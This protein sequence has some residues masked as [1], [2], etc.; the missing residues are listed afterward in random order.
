MG[1]Q[2]FVW[3]LLALALT[4]WCEFGYR[5][6]W[7]DGHLDERRVWIYGVRRDS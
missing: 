5:R 7:G 3:Y 4:G 2:D 6:A 1:D